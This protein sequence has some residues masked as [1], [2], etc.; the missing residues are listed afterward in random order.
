[1]AVVNMFDGLRTPRDI[2]KYTLSR[3]VTDFG[4]VGQYELYETG[5][6]FLVLV[7]IPNFLEKLAQKNADYNTLITNYKHILE[8]EFRGL[9]GLDNITS[10]VGTITNGISNLDIITKVEQQSNATFSMR[11]FEKAG[12]VI[13]RTHELFLTG[14]K[15]PRTQVKHYHGL[16]QDGTIQEPGYEHEVFSFLYFVTDNTQTKIEKAYFIVSA[17]PTT[18]E[19]SMYESEKGTIE[20]KEITVEFRGF[21][22]TG[23]VVNKKAQE[24]LDWINNPKNPNHI[25]NNSAE[26]VYSGTENIIAENIQ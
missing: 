13:T 18:A 2:T 22:I 1:M 19:T 17:Q 15:D 12:S 8:Y 11:Y 7:S 6:S 9:D 4:N 10:D 24:V 21:P 26:F 14:I 16:I 20:F 5:Y 23:N 25:T 3:G